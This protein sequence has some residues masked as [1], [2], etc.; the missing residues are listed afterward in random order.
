LH[1]LQ[2]AEK[3]LFLP[4]IRKGYIELLALFGH[5][6]LAQAID[7]QADALRGDRK[8]GIIEVVI[9][10]GSDASD[11]VHS[12]V[13]L[14]V[15]LRVLSVGFSGWLPTGADTKLFAH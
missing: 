6:T 9:E 1:G 3:R 14:R 4:R 7:R 15:V 11:C 5:H 2:Q 10:D 13:S 12:D 8:L